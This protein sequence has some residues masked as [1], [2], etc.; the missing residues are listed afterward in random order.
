MPLLTSTI[1]GWGARRLTEM[2][3]LHWDLVSPAALL[4]LPFAMRAVCQPTHLAHWLRMRL[5]CRMETDHR[6]AAA[7]VGVT[8]VCWQLIRWTIVPSGT[9][10]NITLPLAHRGGRLASGNSVS[11]RAL[12]VIR[13]QRLLQTR[14]L[15]Q[16]LPRQ[17][18]LGPV[19][20]V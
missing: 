6:Q 10:Q 5:S 16:L 19:Y 20:S 13:V 15:P 9:Q 11:R 17:I 1:A 14:L 2:A 4:I 3:T 12:A 18:A 7:V 8:I